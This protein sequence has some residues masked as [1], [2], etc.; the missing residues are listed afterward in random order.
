CDDDNAKTT[1][2]IANTEHKTTDDDNSQSNREED[3]DKNSNA[4]TVPL[5][6]SYGESTHKWFVYGKQSEPVYRRL[7]GLIGFIIISFQLVVYI[8]IISVAVD[9][10][11]KD[12]VPVMIN[13]GRC[14]QVTNDD[15]MKMDILF[16]FGNA[17]NDTSSSSDNLDND[18]STWFN[19]A[20]YISAPESFEG[21]P[22]EQTDDAWLFGNYSVLNQSH[23][24]CEADTGDFGVGMAMLIVMLSLFLTLDFTDAISAIRHTTGFQRAYAVYAFIEVFTTWAA[25]VAAGTQKVWTGNVVDALETGV[26]LLFV[27]D[28]GNR[29]FVSFKARKDG[30]R[31]YRLFFGTALFLIAISTCFA[32]GLTFLTQSYNSF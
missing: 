5:E 14:G 25:C 30:T 18:I 6:F 21:D 12:L 16:G 7:D 15:T 24:Y 13:F 2:T 31:K 20:D 3:D 28:L 9:D 4:S 10:F 17:T 32:I 19:Y 23:L 26:G 22:Q 27:H 29:V 8:W 1:P 11:Q